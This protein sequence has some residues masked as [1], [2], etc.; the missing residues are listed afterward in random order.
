MAI[1]DADLPGELLSDPAGDRDGHNTLAAWMMT[2]P[3][4]GS[5]YS[6][7]ISPLFGRDLAGRVVHL[8]CGPEQKESVEW[9]A[10]GGKALLHRF[11]ELVPVE[12]QTRRLI[13]N[14]LMCSFRL[15]EMSGSLVLTRP[16]KPDEDFPWQ[17]ACPNLYPYKMR[18]DTFYQDGWRLPQLEALYVKRDGV[19]QQQAEAAATKLMRSWADR[20]SEHDYAAYLNAQGEDFFEGLLAEGCTLIP[21]FEACNG[22]NKVSADF[23]LQDYWPGRVVKGLHEVVERR[24]D[25]APEGTILEVIKPGYA[26]PHHIQQAQVIVSDGSGYKT[27]HQND[28]APLVPDLRLPHQRT[29]GKWG[30]CWLPTHPSHFEAPAIWGWEDASGHF[31]QLRGPLWDPL[32]YYYSSVPR[33]IE[34]HATS[35]LKKNPWLVKVP[36]DM[37]LKFHPIVPMRGYDIQRM[38]AAEARRKAKN[39][40]FTT[41]VHHDDGEQSCD[42]GY[43]PLPLLFEFELDNW[44]FPELDPRKRVESTVPFSLESR[45]CPVIHSAVRPAAYVAAVDTGNDQTPVWWI[46]AEKMVAAEGEVLVDYPQLH[47]YMTE[48]APA[49]YEFFVPKNLEYLPP[50]MLGVNAG[51]TLGPEVYEKLEAIAPGL[52]QELGEFFDK[53]QR[54]LRLRYRL[55]TEKPEQ[56]AL[57]YWL[58]TPPDELVDLLLDDSETKKAEAADVMPSAAFVDPP[59]L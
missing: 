5:A 2:A 58:G 53:A 17:Y 4:L 44:W 49:G 27:P 36:D 23:D 15:V 11:A 40:P 12:A 37:R 41:L 30:A 18:L 7:P 20:S 34:A 19:T 22:Y 14:V 21:T 24:P 54:W 48:G 26:L 8:G 51:Q 52:Y 29:S 33:V 43:H 35:R 46:N 6:V 32:H 42:V 31:V 50:E 16:D 28:P 57:A 45:L 25:N 55:Y 3:G 38:A 56:Y 13:E 59:V 47:R 9:P 39:P 1:T 10:I